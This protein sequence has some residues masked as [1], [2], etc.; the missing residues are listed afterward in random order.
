[1]NSK[2]DP[3]KKVR[4]LLAGIRHCWDLSMVMPCDLIVRAKMP[5]G[6]LPLEGWLSPKWEN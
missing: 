3:Q 1:M 6:L 5:K 2:P 4:K